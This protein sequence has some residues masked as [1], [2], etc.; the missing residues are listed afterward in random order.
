VLALNREAMA[1]MH[2][3]VALR[4]VRFATHLFEEAGALEQVAELAAGWFE[5]HLTAL[6]EEAPHYAGP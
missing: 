5:R 4:V 2:A 6:S 1:R 3:R